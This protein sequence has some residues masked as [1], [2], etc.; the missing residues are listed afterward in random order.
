M[1]VAFSGWRRWVLGAWKVPTE[2][3]AVI[4]PRLL[5]VTQRFG[6][7][8]AIMRDLGRAVQDAGDELVAALG[9]DI[10]VLACHLHFLRDVGGDLLRSAHDQLRAL[11]RRFQVKPGL[12][13][14]ARDLGARWAPRSPRR[15][16]A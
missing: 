7:P 12:R 13:S 14:L 3:A 5:D 4:L 8:C 15:A 10:P 1:L 16:R 9:R 6:A 11:F 2:R